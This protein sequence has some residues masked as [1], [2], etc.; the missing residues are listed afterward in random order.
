V[1]YSKPSLDEI[2]KVMRPDAVSVE[3]KPAHQAVTHWALLCADDGEAF[4][5]LTA[6]S[7]NI[8]QGIS[9]GKATI[10][11]QGKADA[12]ALV[13]R[14]TAARFRCRWFD[15]LLADDDRAKMVK[16]FRQSEFAVLVTTDVLPSAFDATFLVVNWTPPMRGAHSPTGEHLHPAIYHRRAAR[17]G[18]LGRTG[19]CVTFARSR[20]EL[21]E[22]QSACGESGVELNLITKDRIAEVPDE[23]ALP[24]VP[25]EL[26]A[27]AA[28]HDD[29]DQRQGA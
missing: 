20:A 7:E 11:V 19:I 4:E 17:A 25:V 3:L 13:D 12:L 21:G 1:V 22:L 23:Q 9:Y 10:F 26:R 6:L 28:A 15:S 2:A 18:R 16:D 14:L 24:P 27:A 8:S 5:A 29:A